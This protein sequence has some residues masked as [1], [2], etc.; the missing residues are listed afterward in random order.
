[1]TELENHTLV[2]LREMRAEMREEFAKVR[3]EAD[4]RLDRI[5][6]RLDAMHRNGLKAL[7]GFIG[8]RAMVER[9]TASFEDQMARLE[10]RMQALENAGP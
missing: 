7:K 9:T 6:K 4:A 10:L 8:H 1:M 5:E 2:L 3:G